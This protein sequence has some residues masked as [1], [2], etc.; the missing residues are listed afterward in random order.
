MVSLSLTVIASVY[1]YTHVFIST[2]H[3]LYEKAICMHVV[4]ADHLSLENQFVFFS[5]KA[6]FL[7]PNHPWLDALS[8]LCK[9]EASW[10]LPSILAFSLVLT[11]FSTHLNSH[12]EKIFMD[13]NLDTYSALVK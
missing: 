6:I 5:G 7:I 9:I 3:S 1:V 13:G 10:L 4:M 11:L 2:T 12:I 8:Y